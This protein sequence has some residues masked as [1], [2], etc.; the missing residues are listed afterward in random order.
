MAYHLA[1]AAWSNSHF[2]HRL[3][4]KGARRTTFLRRYGQ[5]FDCVE[6][7]LTAY[8]HTEP[9]D[10]ADWI[11]WSEPGFRFM[12]KMVMRA[13]HGRKD[14][15]ALGAATDFVDLLRPL[16]EADRLGPVLLQFPAAFK[17]SS[18]AVSYLERLLEVVPDPVGVEFR[19][20]SWDDPATERLLQDH[21]ACFVW[22]TYESAPRAAWATTDW[23][24]IRLVGR[25]RERRGEAKRL[26]DRAVDLQAVRW[27]L[28]EVRPDWR[29][30][31][32][33]ATNRFEGDALWTLPR[34]AEAL[35]VPF[36]A[37]AS[38]AKPQLA[39]RPGQ[40]TL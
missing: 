10:I 19:D 3:Y 39:Y 20:P 28:D 13:T 18:N 33:V 11:D 30:C 2:G 6:A 40:Q 34:A 7:D 23:G 37:P 14:D 38:W 4:G 5:W 36:E 32:I 22:S 15:G 31:F 25:S 1:L 8:G 21:D 9:E 12:P 17:R 16:R 24:W 35:G 27:R 26:R 29:E